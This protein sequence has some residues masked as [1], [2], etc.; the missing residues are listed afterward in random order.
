MARTLLSEGAD[1][2]ELDGMDVVPF[3]WRACQVTP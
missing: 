3:T 1:G 2:K